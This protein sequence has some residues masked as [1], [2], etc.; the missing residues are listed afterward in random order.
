[1][2]QLKR[3]RKITASTLQETIIALSIIV[4]VFGIAL[5]VLNNLMRVENIHVQFKGNLLVEKYFDHVTDTTEQHIY[6]ND[7]FVVERTFYPHPDDSSLMIMVVKVF[8]SNKKKI[9]Q[10][11][12]ILFFRSIDSRQ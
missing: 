1:M 7:G 8:D 4:F 3:K 6:E 5:L 9:A 2:A 10:Q 12:E 11:K